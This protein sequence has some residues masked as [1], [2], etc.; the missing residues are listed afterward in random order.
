MNSTSQLDNLG[1]RRWLDKI[2]PELLT[3]AHETMLTPEEGAQAFVQF[4]RCNTEKISALAIDTK[5]S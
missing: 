3:K 1:Q 2:T 5:E 4:W